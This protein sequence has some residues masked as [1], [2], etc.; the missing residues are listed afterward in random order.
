MSHRIGVDI[1]GTF[2][3]LVL[4]DEDGGELDQTKTPSTPAD[5]S[6][7]ASNG[8]EKLLDGTDVT[9]SDID[10]IIHGTTV[11]TNTVIESDGAATALVTTDGFR[12]VLEIGRQARPDL[13]D[14][15]ATNPDPLV[16]RERRLTA[17]EKIGPDGA[18]KRPL[19]DDAVSAVVD[20]LAATGVDAVAICLLHSYANDTHER[21]LAAAIER[22]LP[23]IDT[24][25]SS[26]ILPEYRE[27]ERLSTTVINAYVQPR[28]ASYINRLETRLA[29]LGITA[30]LQIMQSNG[31]LMTAETASEKS[32][33]TL[34][35]GPS[36]G[37]LAGQ[38]IGELTDTE[39]L[40]TF[41]MGGTSAD[42]CTIRG[43]EPE[44]SVENELGGHP[45]RVRMLDINAIGAGG[46]SV[47]WIDRGGAL[48]VGPKSAGSDP[49]PVCYGHG[50]TEPTVTD[51]NLVLGRLNPDYLLEGD[52]AV[53]YDR[54]IDQ[55]EESLADPLGMSV[56]AAAEGVMDVVT[57]NMVR[58]IRGVSV[59]R[60]YD[61]RE[62]SLVAFGGAGPLHAH[63]LIRELEMNE[64]IVPVTPGVASSFGLLS[65]NTKH[66]YVRTIVEDLD[67]LTPGKLE[68]F[69]RD[70]E[71]EAEERL[72]AENVGDATAT[73]LADMKYDRQGYE[74]TVTVP[75]SAFSEGLGALAETFEREHEREYGFVLD[76]E[77]ID[78]VNVR[79]QT[80]ATTD[81]PSLRAGDETDT[82]ASVARVDTR[83]TV[84]DGERY[85]A[86]IYKRRSLKPGHVVAGP[87]VVEELSSTTV[88]APGQRASVDEYGII[89]V[90]EGTT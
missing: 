66:S 48:R 77:P 63:R 18:V 86:G 29:D 30:P 26:E 13:Y 73:R 43:G 84:F 50:G 88:V 22:R 67:A 9:G 51:A 42:I 68:E 10:R 44:Y 40:I 34:L 90:T 23:E 79:L 21:Q 87:A 59:E 52:L 47:G 56:E 83:E 69:Y 20:E 54:T 17:P 38:F 62:S 70:L 12:D 58:G 76:A 4:F 71:A 41:D 53:E 57:A 28:M 16:P 3:D 61:P 65:A 75:E 39:N 60:G 24:V 19:D 15:W 55:F 46:G 82:D 7:G 6:Q 85:D 36:A 11:A 72:A 27:Y 74:L 45:V 37:V 78:V 1:G 25:L 32:V 8:I 89:H 5:P 80:V 14:F 49:G 33:H 81:P 2:T 64:A 35:S 31:G